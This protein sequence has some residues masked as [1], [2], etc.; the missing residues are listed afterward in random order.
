MTYFCYTDGACK[1]GDG[2]PGGW[3]FCIKCPDGTWL[4]GYGR[5]TDTLAKVMEYRAV[6]EALSQVPPGATVEVFCD[7]ASLVE[8]FTR[9]L[10]TWRANGFSK[11][12]A[13]IA[14]WVR[15][16]DACLIKKGLEVRWTWVRAHNGNEGNERADALAGQGAREARAE[17]KAAAEA[18]RLKG[19]GGHRH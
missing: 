17:L 11:V 15:Q 1:A 9:N 19:R 5:A 18:E 2:A 10:V 14:P 16:A 8:N 6:A 13:T 4:E 7:N 3:G 12:D